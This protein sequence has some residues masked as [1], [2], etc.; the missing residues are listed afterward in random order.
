MTEA[1]ILRTL[2][3]ADVFS[4]PLTAKE[5]HR[6]LI[7]KKNVSVNS[8]NSAL[9]V[10]Q[11]KHSKIAKVGQYYTLKGR[12]H[13]IT[14]RRHREAWSQP[15]LAEA[16]RVGEW[17][18]LI[19]T[20]SA[21]SVTGAL[22]MENTDKFDDIDLLIVTVPHSLWLTRLLVVPLVSLIAKRRK[23][24]YPERSRRAK[25]RHPQNQEKRQLTNSICLNLWLDETALSLP[26]SR[27]NLYTAH[28][29]AQAKTLWSRGEV[30][31]IFLADNR[32]VFSYL[33]N[34]VTPTKISK[35]IFHFPFSIFNFLNR[36]AFRLQQSYMKKR[37]TREVV[38]P[39]SAFFHP[40]NMK[41][42]VMTQYHHRLKQLGL[43]S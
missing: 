36:L 39:H 33:P 7:S 24:V 21:V 8:V 35:K 38:T 2:A 6:W 11:K 1:A 29:V 30:E 5:I 18:R 32:W 4:Y 28:E 17:L 25:R 16:R 19:P 12:S 37:L 42:E 27:L 15:K 9:S 3:Y 10:L 34:I 41:A 22:A 31:K 13:L 43:S 14:V 40:Q 26:P 23:P 20:I